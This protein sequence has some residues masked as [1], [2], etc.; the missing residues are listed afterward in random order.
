LTRLYAVV[1]LLSD[2][3]LRE[4]PVWWLAG[5][6]PSPSATTQRETRD[7]QQR[8]DDYIV[9]SWGD[10]EVRAHSQGSMTS[11]LQC[12]TRNPTAAKQCAKSSRQWVYLWL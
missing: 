3:S 5:R 11:N 1:D 4:T 12:Y 8:M 6:W 9:G 7:Q 2:I 10:K